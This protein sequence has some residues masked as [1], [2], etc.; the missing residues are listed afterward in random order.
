MGLQTKGRQTT[1]QTS[2]TPT[3]LRRQLA[4]CEHGNTHYCAP[5]NLLV[6]VPTAG[7]LPESALEILTELYLQSDAFTLLECCHA[8]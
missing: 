2:P 7:Y 8:P 1:P 3:A 6:F 5:R 4:R